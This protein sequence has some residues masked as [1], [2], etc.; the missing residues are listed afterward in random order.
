MILRNWK[1]IL[2]KFMKPD[3]PLLKK[4]KIR[5]EKNVRPKNKGRKSVIC[6]RKN[7]SSPVDLY[8][9]TTKPW[10]KKPPN[11]PNK[12]KST[13]KSSSPT[14]WPSSTTMTT[15]CPKTDQKGPIITLF[16]KLIQTK[17]SKANSPTTTPMSFPN[18]WV[19]W[20]NVENN[21]KNN[22]KKNKKNLSNLSLT[23]MM[24]ADKSKS[25]NKD[26]WKTTI[27]TP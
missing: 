7:A 23:E 17:N 26:K 13:T 20:K 24:S 12:S 25:S 9:G 4:N 22:N 21:S 15:T 6:T 11:S 10:I 3:G 2:R 5:S 27:S 8:P 14:P 16:K 18:L 1:K 19:T